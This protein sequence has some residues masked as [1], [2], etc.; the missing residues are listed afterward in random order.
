MKG[1][2]MMKMEPWLMEDQEW[3]GTGREE[4]GDEESRLKMCEVHSPTPCR[5]HEHVH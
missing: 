1:K 3:E 2:Q 4:E 5:C